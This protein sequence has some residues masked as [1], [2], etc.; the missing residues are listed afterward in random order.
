MVRDHH[1]MVDPR[2]KHAALLHSPSYCQTLQ[3]N[4]RVSTFGV[5]KE[6]RSSLNELP[7]ILVFLQ[8]EEA[9]PQSTCICV[10]TRL[11]S[12]VK[13]GEGRCAGEDVL[14]AFECCFMIGCPQE[15]IS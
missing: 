5:R 7:I 1:E 4:D 12:K 15:V 11:L 3:L 10:E 6:P 2:E 9:N 8:Q 13:E 14:G